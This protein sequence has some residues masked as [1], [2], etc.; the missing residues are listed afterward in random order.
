MSIQSNKKEA[1]KMRLITKLLVIMLL[2]L[3]VVC[4]LSYAEIPHLI[5]Y[6]G[7][8]TDNQGQPITG[9]KSVTFRI[10]D[11]ESGGSPLW[12]ETHT[13]TFDRGIFNLFIGGVTALNLPFNKPYYLGIQ[14]GDDPEMTP[15]QRFASVGYAFTAENGVPKGTIVMW[16]GTIASIPSG[17]ALCD[18]TNGTPDLRNKFVKCVSNS[19]T[20]PGATG[21]SSTVTL[22]EANL[23]PHTHTGP[24]HSHNI[25]YLSGGYSGGGTVGN[26]S[27]T[28]TNNAGT[29]MWANWNTSVYSMDN[30]G[31]GL[32][33]SGSGSSTLFNIAPPYYEIAFIM[34]IE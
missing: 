30:A 17:W 31:E 14:V 24:S 5:N 29:T 11:T 2:L 25:K 6:Q 34:K 18:G 4:G 32:T 28:P 15:R 7:R 19:L 23:P 26:L 13:A 1:I 20:N 3:S 27:G 22:I 16:S 12:Q 33:G 9:T 21:G 8:L 10:Y